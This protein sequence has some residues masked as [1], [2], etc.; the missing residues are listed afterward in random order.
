M[1][2]L[3]VDL[4]HISLK[5]YLPAESLCGCKKNIHIIYS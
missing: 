2:R 1:Y 5:N 3:Y 4:E